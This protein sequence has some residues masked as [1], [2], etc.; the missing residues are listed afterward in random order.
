LQMQ[1]P[2]M[3]GKGLGLGEGF[4]FVGPSLDVSGS[5]DVGWFALVSASWVAVGVAIVVCELV[6]AS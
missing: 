1:P 4:A 2:V 6:A 3:L 5:V